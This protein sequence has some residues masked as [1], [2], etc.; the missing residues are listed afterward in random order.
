MEYG[1]GCDEPNTIEKTEDVFLILSFAVDSLYE[2]KIIILFLMIDFG[3][4]YHNNVDKILMIITYK[5]LLKNL[6]IVDYFIIKS[7][8]IQ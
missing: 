2:N 5:Q 1:E 3:H 6:N 8:F 4:Y 7:N